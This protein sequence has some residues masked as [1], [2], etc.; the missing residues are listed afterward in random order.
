MKS[1][2]MI[3]DDFL[4]AA[5][6]VGI[7]LQLM[8]KALVQQGYK[9]SILT[10][11]RKGQAPKEDWNGV[12][13]YRSPSIKAFGFYQ[14]LPSQ[15]FIRNILENENPD[16]IH[17]H[18]LSFMLLKVFFEVR[19]KQLAKFY[20]YHMTEDHLT[21]PLPMRPLRR[22]LRHLI[23]LFCNKMDMVISP[24]ANLAQVIKE[25]GVATPL[26]WI[27]NPVEFGNTS[28][29][30]P[31]R[32]KSPFTIL[33]AGRLAIEKNIPFLLHGFARLQEM[34]IKAR[35]E[36]AGHGPEL[37][38][39][40]NLAR[41]LNIS[42]EVSFLGQLEHKELAIHYANCDVFVLPSL[43]ETQGMVAM[44]AMR[45]SKPVI[46]TDKIVSA[47]ELVDHCINGFIVNSDSAAELAERLQQLAMDENL[48]VNMGLSSQTRT[49][50]FDLET[51][52][53]KLSNLYQEF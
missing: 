40:Q 3:S 6:G 20:T 32:G 29:P 31:K 48:K 19:T 13:V 52:A 46:V 45:F 25:S 16:V 27:N 37:S 21:A 5:T 44:E 18:Y 1:I 4:P 24:S 23:R 51:V 33:Y 9:V 26:R 42:E 28:L 35:L 10:S 15:S 50:A 11:R 49:H 36:I 12:T 39:L 30:A 38:S 34:G 43:V 8:S 17:F 14:A 53:E 2:L 7:H 47:K 22:P 41:K